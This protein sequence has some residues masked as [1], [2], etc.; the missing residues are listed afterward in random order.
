MMTPER[1]YAALLTLYPKAFREAYGGDVLAAFNE[2]RRANRRPPLVFWRF[3]LVDLA[4]SIGQEQIDECMRGQRRYVLRWL[5]VCALGIIGTG[6][7][8]SVVTR[9]FGYLYHPYLEGLQFAPWSYGALVGAGLGL[10]QTAALRSRVRAGLAWIAASA[11]ST[12]L[13]FHLAAFVTVALG[14]VGCGMAIGAIVGGCQWMLA[15]TRMRR[16]GRVVM[17]TAAS[18]PIAILLCDSL[19]QRALAGMNPVAIDAQARTLAG[20]QYGT[21][22]SVLVRGLQQPSSWSDVAFE[23]AAMAVSGLTI[24]AITARQLAGG[25]HASQAGR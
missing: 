16:P 7:A 6:L 11:A 18:L 14:P 3:A 4:R 2:L 22:I 19:I 5:A 23:F 8:S 21:A 13:G 17:A 10:A 12:A 20:P 15:R 25:H 9:G 1:F 24:G